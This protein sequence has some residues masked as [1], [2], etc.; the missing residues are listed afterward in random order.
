MQQLHE[1]LQELRQRAGYDSAKAFAK[2]ANIPYSTYSSYEKGTSEPKATALVKIATALSTT[3]D[4][5]L[6]Y[7]VDEF[8]RAAALFHEATGEKVKLD[9][10]GEKVKFYGGYA[11]R[12][13][14]RYPLSRA[15]FLKAVHDSLQTLDKTVIPQLIRQTLISHIDEE[16]QEENKF[17]LSRD[18]IVDA[19]HSVNERNLKAHSEARSIM[20]FVDL[21]SGIGEIKLKPVPDKEL[22]KI[23]EKAV[24]EAIVGAAEKVVRE[25]AKKAKEKP[26]E[27]TKRKGPHSKK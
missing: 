22:D 12:W 25:R 23:V 16:Y 4:S 15:A 24:D 8:E 26:Q 9:S 1:R 7:N 17:S 11:S 27:Q 3:V 10:T 2:A 20:R 19:L 21:F 13:K 6:N 14:W 18:V 5:V